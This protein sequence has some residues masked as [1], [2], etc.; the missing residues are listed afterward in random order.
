M[1]HYSSYIK[2]YDDVSRKKKLHD[3]E[4]VLTR[5]LDSTRGIIGSALRSVALVWSYARPANVVVV[6]SRSIRALDTSHRSQLEK[7][8]A[9]LGPEAGGQPRAHAPPALILE[10]FW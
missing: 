3:D 1:I 10:S 6:S 7:E 5:P 8:T 9:A 2:L 4:P